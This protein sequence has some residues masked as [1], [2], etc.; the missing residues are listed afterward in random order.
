[1]SID[2]RAFPQ[3][4]I[5]K[6]ISSIRA[7]APLIHCITNVVTVNDCAN[8]LLAIG[9]SPIMAQDIHEAA[10]VTSI[11]SA[12]VCNLGA[13][14]AF[15]SIE[16]SI[17]EASRLDIPVVI[18]P[19]GITAS[20]YRRNFCIRLLK[21]GKVNAIRCNL[22]E[23]QCLL[24]DDVHHIGLDSP[25]QNISV[26]ETSNIANQAISFAHKYNVIIAVT[27]QNDIAA[28]S[29]KAYVI[30]GGDPMI[31]RI[32]G[33]GCMSSVVLGAF[34]SITKTGTDPDDLLLYAA[35]SCTFMRMMAKEAASDTMRINGGT[36]TFRDKLI[37]ACSR[38]YITH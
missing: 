22:S 28:D 20:T 37:D 38:F 30:G 27:G 35:R 3:S 8:I 31:K 5:E 19:V 25:E 17:I 14:N 24:Y 6:Q 18:D 4:E 13:V 12:L 36:I 1:M 32:T 34:L 11:A 15:S 16:A 26:D 29:E 21:S 10:E 33:G 23:M 2:T 9:A 7:A